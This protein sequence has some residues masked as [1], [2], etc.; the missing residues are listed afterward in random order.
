MKPILEV[1]N[2]W[3]KY[4]IGGQKASY[5][6]LRER[7]VQG[8]K[9]SKEETFWALQDINFDVHEGE[10]IGIIGQ[11]GAGK[12]TLLKILSQITPPT[13][14]YIKARGRV[15]SLLEVGTGFHPE[16][17]G[18]ENIFLNGSI[19]GLRRSE[20]KAKFDAIVEFSG[21]EQFLDTPL[22]HY[23]S[24]MRLRLAFSVAAYLEPE[25]LLI[26]EVLAV[27]DV[28]FQKK[29]LGKMDEVSKSG[30]TVLFVSHNLGAVRQLCERSFL[31]NHGKIQN[32]GFT[33]NI[34]N[35]Y[36]SNKKL[37]KSLVEYSSPFPGS[38]VTKLIKASCI[39]NNHSN[40][41]EFNINQAIGIKITYKVLKPNHVLHFGIK[42]YNKEDVNIF[43]SHS[44][45]SQWYLK[46]HPTGIYE[47]IGWIPANILMSGLYSISIAIFNHDKH[48]IHFFEEKCLHLSVLEVPFNAKSPT[49]GGTNYNKLNGIIRPLLK[50]ETTSCNK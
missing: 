30:R 49:A 31:L 17:T 16:L 39:D 38:D 11:N 28:E 37:T 9:R 22:K 20:I 2:L 41:F 40:K 27:G 26:D 13:K 45:T 21:I 4:K 35:E 43:D 14:G 32:I 36:L 18:R 33:S 5:L 42:V 15:A 12:S 29:C 50:W 24:G 6:N 1:R 48:T 47:S 44:V 19:L 46:P 25:I 7:L 34:I 23:S 10:C 8:F 3:K